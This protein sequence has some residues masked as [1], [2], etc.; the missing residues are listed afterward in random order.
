MLDGFECTR[1]LRAGGCTTPIVA[2]TANA[3]FACQR[4]CY[5]CGFDV[6]LNKPLKSD[7]LFFTVAALP[8]FKAYPLALS[9]FFMHQ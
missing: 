2:L 3:T 5:E 4:R 9:P 7:A 1:L 6:F 8:P